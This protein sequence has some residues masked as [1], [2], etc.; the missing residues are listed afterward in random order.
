MRPTRPFTALLILSVSACGGRESPDASA[1]EAPEGSDEARAAAPAGRA[2]AEPVAP[3]VPAGTSLTF[4]V[5]EEVSTSDHQAGHTFTSTLAGDGMGV[6]GATAVPAGSIGRWVVTEATNDN[7]QGESV[8]AMKLEAV[9]VNGTW[10]PV[11]ATVTEAELSSDQKDS[12]T[13]TAAKIGI[14]AAAG[15]IAGKVLGGSTEAT[16]KGAGVGAALG[17]AIALTTRGGSATLKQGAR[18]TVSLD[19]PLRLSPS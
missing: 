18:I 8:L 12:N 6:D 2:A 15:A 16:L 7:A 14:G 19:E 1:A 11:V 13:K 9:S 5:N 17:T 10:Y 4:V 3:V